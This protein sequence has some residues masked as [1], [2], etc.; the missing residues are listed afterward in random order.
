MK[1]QIIILKLDSL[2]LYAPCAPFSSFEA[3]ASWQGYGGLTWGD[4]IGV[5]AVEGV[6]E[7]GEAGF[8]WLVMLN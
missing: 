5:Q 7:E 3:D 6:D 1:S 8:G 4:D 2:S